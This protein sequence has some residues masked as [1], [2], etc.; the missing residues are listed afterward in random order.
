M[1]ESFGGEKRQINEP[2]KFFYSCTTKHCF[3]GLRS[4]H[5]LTSAPICGSG[6]TQEVLGYSGSGGT[7][8]LAKLFQ[9]LHTEAMRHFSMLN[10]SYLFI[11]KWV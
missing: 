9:Q 6:G 4:I 7:Q 8:E 10:N 1:L 2:V 11:C 5:F 3:P